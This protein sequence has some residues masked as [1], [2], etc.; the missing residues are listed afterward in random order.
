VAT[1]TS[2]AKGYLVSEE[3]NFLTTDSHLAVRKVLDQYSHVA[4]IQNDTDDVSLAF[5]AT[6]LVRLNVETRSNPEMLASKTGEL[7]TL[8]RNA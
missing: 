6:L 5:S 1:T 3:T 7:S 4:F 8:L 2:G